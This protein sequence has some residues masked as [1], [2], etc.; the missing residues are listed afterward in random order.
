[1][2]KRYFSHAIPADGK[3]PADVARIEKAIAKRKRRAAK[4][5]AR[6]VK[7]REAA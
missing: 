2:S 3:T 5:L 1:M 4:V 7:L 6:Q